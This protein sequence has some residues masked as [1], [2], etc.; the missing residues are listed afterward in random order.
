[1]PRQLPLL[2][3]Y[4]DLLARPGAYSPEHWYVEGTRAIQ[5]SPDR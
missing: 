4:R 3:R 5:S 1:M 2:E